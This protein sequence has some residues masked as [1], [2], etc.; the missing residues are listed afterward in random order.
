MRPPRDAKKKKDGASEGCSSEGGSL[1]R[2]KN[3]RI[4]DAPSEMA[5]EFGSSEGGSLNRRMS[6]QRCAFQETPKNSVKK[7]AMGKMRSYQNKLPQRRHPHHNVII[8]PHRP[9]I[10]FVTV[11]TKDRL[12]WLA[13]PEVHETLVSIWR[14]A[15]AWR[16]GRYILLPDHLHLFASP[17]EIDVSLSNWVRFWKAEFSKRHGNPQHR[18]QQG[19]WDTQLRRSENYDAKW[20]YVRH[21]PVR[22]GLVKHPDEWPYQGEIFVLEW[23]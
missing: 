7:V 15:T 1:N 5:K 3:R 14:M 11:C 16:V 18:W 23:W 22:H 4:K 8:V 13:S 10:V 6:H 21:N 19:Y 17:G 12:P 9:I 20:E 2:R